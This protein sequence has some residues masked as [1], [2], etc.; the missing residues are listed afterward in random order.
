[1]QAPVAAAPQN[2]NELDCLKAELAREK[3]S[4][5]HLENKCKILDDSN[6]FIKA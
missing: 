2:R 3:D 6:S 4:N 5:L 1:M